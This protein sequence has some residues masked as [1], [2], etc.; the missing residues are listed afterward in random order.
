MKEWLWPARLA[1]GDRVGFDGAAHTITRLCARRLTLVDTAGDDRQ[2]DAVALLLHDD[3][4][5]LDHE[6]GPDHAAADTGH[7]TDV[8]GSAQ[9]WE[10]HILD[11]APLARS[12]SDLKLIHGGRRTTPPGWPT[13]RCSQW[14]EPQS[15]SH[16]AHRA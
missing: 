11:L 12:P 7:G 13:H 6:S 9:W 2:V 8:V 4:A 5:V 15:V 1:V 14:S 16:R 10:S 3:F